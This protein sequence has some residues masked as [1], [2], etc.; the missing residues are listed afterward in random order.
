MIFNLAFS[1]TQKAPGSGELVIM[2]I[3]AMKPFYEVGVISGILFYYMASGAFSKLNKEPR[4][5]WCC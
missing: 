2:G 4:F 3:D 1:L 5:G